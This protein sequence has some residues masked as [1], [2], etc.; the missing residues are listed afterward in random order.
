MSLE[1]P[2]YNI[3]IELINQVEETINRVIAENFSSAEQAELT[4]RPI[5]PE[6]LNESLTME[7]RTYVTTLTGGTTWDRILNATAD[8]K[9]PVGSVYLF[10]G[11]FVVEDPSHPIGLDCIGRI[12]ISNV[13][14]D[15]TL[16][17]LVNLQE[18]NLYIKFKNIIVVKPNTTISIQIKGTAGGKAI[19][20]P[21]A[22]RIGPKAQLNPT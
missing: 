6:E 4:Y 17:S 10:M 12:Y 19:I 20:Y 21:F 18:N 7:T 9:P 11:W 13:L 3:P 14:Q 5:R 16:L 2:I 22:F 15:E 1:L 8:I